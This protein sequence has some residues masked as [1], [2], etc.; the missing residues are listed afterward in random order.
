MVSGSISLPSPGFFSPFPHGTCALSVIR[1]CLALEGGPPSFPRDF[2]C[3]VV[4]RIPLPLYAYFAYKDYHLLWSAF[5]CQF[6]YKHIMVL[7]RSY[8]L[9]HA[10]LRRHGGFGL[11]PL[12]SPLL[13]ESRLISLP[14]PTEMFHF[15]RFASYAYVF[16]V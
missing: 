8:N 6:S 14:L 13:R 3:P 2:T 11:F 12:R 4:L 9:P 5:P 1:T 7:S 16:S 10:F 15:G